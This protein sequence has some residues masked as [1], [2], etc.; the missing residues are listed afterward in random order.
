MKT[1][2]LVSFIGLSLLI[3]FN[4]V[5]A[6]EIELPDPGLTPDSP[7]Y[8]LETIIEEIGTFFTFGDLKK[9]ERHA[10]LAAER[11]AEAQVI[12]GKGKPELTEKTLARY[13]MQLQNSMARA[14]KA[15][16]KGENTEEVMAKVG[17]ATSNHLEVLAE[18][19]EKVPEQA[20]PAIE[21]A[22]KASVKGHEKA[23]EALRAQNA[24]G[25]V[26][27]EVSLSEKVPQEVRER[28][29]TR[30]QQELEIEKVLEGVDMSKSLR[31]I[32]TEQGGTPEMCEQFPLQNPESFEAVE[33]FC[34]KIGAPP[35]IC[36]TVEAK[37]KEVGVTTPGK[38][39]LTLLTPTIRRIPASEEQI[40][41]TR[42]QNEAQ[43][44]RRI[45]MEAKRT[46]GALST[47]APLG[48]RFVIINDDMQASRG[49]PVNYGILLTSLGGESAIVP[50]SPAALA[51]LKEGDIILEFNDEI[52]APVN[53]L[54]DIMYR[55][56]AGTTILKVLRGE[57]RI[58]IYV[59]LIEMPTN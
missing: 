26:P 36:A 53:R 51:G 1:K 30:V 28:I 24:L 34:L 15:Q 57:E 11:L 31:D 42:I 9:A 56:E 12:A 6:Q 21:N 23:V 58:T 43:E 44:A 25:E 55:S 54:E 27:E 41:E 13:E 46:A 16:A 20:K 10:A 2:I 22:M 5:Q 48:I 4:F 29:Q 8:F 47:K 50:G 49:L 38:C 33:A 14:E 17:Q 52:I 19:Y 35:D 18:V 7:L 59:E 45:E 37:C 39:F 32:C 40:E 3:S